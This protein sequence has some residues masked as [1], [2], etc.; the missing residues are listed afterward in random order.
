MVLPHHRDPLSRTNITCNPDGNGMGQ[1][2]GSKGLKPA[3]QS[4][5]TLSS[6]GINETRLRRLL[7][8]AAIKLLKGTSRSHES[9]IF[10]PFGICLKHCAI[11]HPA[12]ASTMQFIASNTSIPVPKIYC[13]FTRKGKTYTAMERINGDI[14]GRGWVKRSSESKAKLLV[15]LKGKVDEMRM[16]RPPAGQGVA[17]IDGG[18][19]WDCRL[20][21][22]SQQYLHGPFA[23]TPDFHVHLRGAT[24]Q[25]HILTSRSLQKCKIDLGRAWCLVRGSEQ[26]QHTR[27]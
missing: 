20:P 1:K 6:P 3:A 24:R 15:Q 11:R 5:S 8:L 21:Q 18:P 26:P 12:E 22:T 13:A 16:I 17:N 4:T 25:T 19:I 9:I 27:P 23:T 2:L 10:A 14:L 7:V